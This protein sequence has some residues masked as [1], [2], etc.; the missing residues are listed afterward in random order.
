MSLTYHSNMYLFNYSIDWRNDLAQKCLIISTV[1]RLN[2]FSSNDADISS[3]ETVEFIS[4]L[5]INRT[6]YISQN[7]LTKR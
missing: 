6:N 4:H 2:V 1:R 3:Q 5:S 7:R